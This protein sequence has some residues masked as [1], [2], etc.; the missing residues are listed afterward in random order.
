MNPYGYDLW[1]DGDLDAGMRETGGRLVLAQ[2]VARCLSTPTGQLLDDPNF[3]Y[4][5]TQWINSDVEIGRPQVAQ[6]SAGITRALL[7]D[8]RILSVDSV[9][10]LAPSTG[11][12][13]VTIVLTGAAGPFTLVLAV[14]DVTVELLQPTSG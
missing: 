6:I 9:V 13:T 1:W 11:I 7:R 12:L 14:S 4:D 8:E 3:G 5:L 10:V 2:W